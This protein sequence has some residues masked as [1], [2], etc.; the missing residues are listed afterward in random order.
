MA[1]KPIS[2]LLRAPAGPVDLAA[3]D[4]RATPGVKGGRKAAEA[5]RVQIDEC[6]ATAQEQ[7]YAHGRT[8]GEKRVLIVLQGMDTSGKGGAIKGLAHAVDPSG[9]QVSAFGRPTAAELKHDF[10]WRFRPA[11]PRPGHVAIFDRS[12][13]EDVVAARVRGVAE[14]RTW[15]RRYGSINRFEER[16][17]AK[18]TLV[19]KCFLHISPQEQRSRLLARLDNPEKHWKFEAGDLDDRALWGQYM[20]AYQDAMER[21]A[22]APS[23]WHVIPADRKWYRDWA[24]AALVSEQLEGLGLGW[25]GGNFD[26]KAMRRRLEKDQADPA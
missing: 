24:L 5:S 14:R 25:P 10:L 11:L 6:L 18:G 20:T 1:K 26:L 21:C 17:A 7:L 23:P 15:I 3:V 2:K 16:L 8:G 19:I 22:S 9:V 12:Y 4:P 13:Y